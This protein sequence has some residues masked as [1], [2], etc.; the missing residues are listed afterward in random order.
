MHSIVVNK[1]A[2]LAY[3]VDL[4]ESCSD[5]VLGVMFMF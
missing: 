2:K 3:M 1:V 5:A 4:E